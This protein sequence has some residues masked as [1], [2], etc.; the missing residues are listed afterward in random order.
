SGNLSGGPVSV[1]WTNAVGVSVSGNSLTKTAADGW[2]NA[3]AASVQSIVSGDGYLEFTASER[4]TYRMC[5][6]ARNDVNQD[7]PSI[8]FAIYLAADGNVYVHELGAQRGNFGAY[9]AGDRLRV[10]IVGGVVKY[11]RNGTV[12]YTS[13][14]T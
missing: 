2:G 12:F 11:S 14:V 3:G 6:L 1:M 13:S 5:G 10:A 8:D 4:T 9:T 7:Y